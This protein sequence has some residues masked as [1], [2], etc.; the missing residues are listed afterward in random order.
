MKVAIGCDHAAI[1]FKQELIAVMK[2]QGYEVQD[3]GSHDPKISVDYPDVAFPLCEAVA[4]GEYDRGVLVCGTGV[5][6][7]IAAN[8]VRGIRCANCS[9]TYSA[10]MTRE[11]NDSN[12][13][14]L[15]AR[16]VGIELAKD[17]LKIWLETPYSQAERHARRVGKITAYENQ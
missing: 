14:T 4:R 8:K 1:D 2:E 11:H 15:G 13:L 12:V 17:V 7:S 6:M 10:R 5:G 3:M 16:T 9:E